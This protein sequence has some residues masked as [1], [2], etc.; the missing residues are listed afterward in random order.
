[1]DPTTKAFL[2]LVQSGKLHAMVRRMGCKDYEQVEDVVQDAILRTLEKGMLQKYDPQKMKFDSFVYRILQSTYIDLYRARFRR[3][4]QEEKQRLQASGM[5][6]EVTFTLL[7]GP[8]S[9]EEPFLNGQ[10]QDVV[11]DQILHTYVLQEIEDYLIRN[12]EI[13]GPF[14]ETP[15]GLVR[16]SHLSVWKLFQEGYTIRE[17]S[18]IFSVRDE[19]VTLF[20][21]E[22][23]CITKD[24]MEAD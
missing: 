3:I 4:P 20:L 19:R 8:D 23:F 2:K 13:L 12:Q 16:F 9:G 7:L 6:P 10:D 1:V 14:L 17:M 21:E 11:S 15:L 24:F 18:R 22:V 5:Y